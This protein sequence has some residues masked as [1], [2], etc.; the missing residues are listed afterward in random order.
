MYFEIEKLK[1][2]TKSLLTAF[3]ILMF[4]IFLFYRK[5]RTFTCKSLTWRQFQKLH[6]FIV[7]THYK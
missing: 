4:R 6:K 3:M 1:V 5:E 2:M 7:I